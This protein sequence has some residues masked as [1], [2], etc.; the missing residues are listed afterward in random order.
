MKTMI[1]FC[2]IA[3]VGCAAHRGPASLNGHPAAYDSM[4]LGNIEANAI[5]RTDKQNVCF[6]I[7]VKMKGVKQ[8]QAQASNWTLAWV[9][10]NKNYHLLNMNQRIPAS[11]PEGGQVVAPYGSYQEW[12]NSFT[13]CAPQ[14]RLSEVHTLVLTPKSIPYSENKG[15]NL[16]WK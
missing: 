15:M 10:Q 2:L 12:S 13:A 14:T 7:H 6:D 11:T 5:K 4:A 16:I 3:F 9:D 8:E 1:V